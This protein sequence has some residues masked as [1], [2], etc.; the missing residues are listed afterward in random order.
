LRRYV[1]VL[2]VREDNGQQK[3][4]LSMKLANQESGEDLDPTGSMALAGAIGG[5]GGAGGGGGRGGG[6]G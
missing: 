1:K 4:G 3:V 2:E 6:R 5:G